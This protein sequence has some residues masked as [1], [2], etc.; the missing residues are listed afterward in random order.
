[1]VRDQ[2]PFD[3]TESSELGPFA[4]S[5]QITHPRNADIGM[6]APSDTFN[7]PTMS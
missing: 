4:L 1:M 2:R 5:K 3:P 7:L 6:T